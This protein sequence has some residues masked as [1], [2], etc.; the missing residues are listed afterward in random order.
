MA[1]WTAYVC[2]LQCGMWRLNSHYE[3]LAIGDGCF[4]A[5]HIGEISN[6]C[7]EEADSYLLTSPKERMIG[8]QAACHHHNN[9]H[10]TAA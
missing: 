2:Q 10:H 3:S 4:L 5:E 8:K 9:V 1:A 7:R 6:N